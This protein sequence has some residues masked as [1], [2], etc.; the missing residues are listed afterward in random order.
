MTINFWN[1]KGRGDLNKLTDN[2]ELDDLF[3][4]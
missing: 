4:V 1:I 2:L 3:Y